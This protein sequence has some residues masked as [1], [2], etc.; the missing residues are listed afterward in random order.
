MVGFVDFQSRRNWRYFRAINCIPISDSRRKN[1]VLWVSCEAKSTHAKY[2][3]HKVE[4]KTGETSA[5]SCYA[6]KSFGKVPRPSF[7]WA[8]SIVQKQYSI[9]GK[10]WTRKSSSSA[11]NCIFKQ[12]FWSF[13]SSCWVILSSQLNLQ[14]KK[15]NSWHDSWLLNNKRKWRESV[16]GK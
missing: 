8:P 2:S 11:L 12:T 7:T 16:P 15:L 13:H 9:L 5:K 14:Q 6:V 1:I 10:N 3:K 4:T